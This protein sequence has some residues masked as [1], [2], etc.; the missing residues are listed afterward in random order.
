[1]QWPKLPTRLRNL[2]QWN[3]RN[4]SHQLDIFLKTTNKGQL[5]EK[6][7]NTD[8]LLV[9]FSEYYESDINLSENIKVGIAYG[10]PS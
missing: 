5:Q 7:Q 6:Y 9:A 4:T 8:S 3:K 2:R 10:L 1:M